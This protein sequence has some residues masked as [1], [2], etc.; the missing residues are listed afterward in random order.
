MLLAALRHCD[1]GAGSAAAAQLAVARDATG[2]L[3]GL[4][5]LVRS[6]RF[7]RLPLPALSNWG[8]P[9][10]FLNA[11][12][13]AQG[14]EDEFWRAII[15]S[16]SQTRLTAPLLHITQLPQHGPVHRGLLSAA[17]ALNLPVIID[18]AVTRA[19]LATND[20]ADAYWDDSVRAKKRKELRRQWARLS[21]Q[22]VLTTDHLGKDADPAPWIAEFLTLEASGWKGANGSSLSSNADTDAFFNEAM[23][24]A[25]AAGQLDLTA[26]RI[27]GRAIAMLITLVGGNCGFSFKTAFDEGFARFSPGVLLQRESLGL[28]VDRQLDWIDSCAAQDHPMIDSLWRER[29]H[30]VSVV[31]P[32]PGRTNAMLFTAFQATKTAWHRIKSLRRTAETPPQ[33]NAEADEK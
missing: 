27:D 16:A 29:R 3:I 25:H 21:E 13:I 15:Q 14:A 30:I 19:A 5:P 8:H 12:S 11:I 10:A 7:G 31:L 17:N 28:L 6:P 1:N 2:A 32:L 4:M 26:L 18:D 24:A 20:S 22:G 33:A 23:R 9:N